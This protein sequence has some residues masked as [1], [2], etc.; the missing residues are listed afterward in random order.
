VNFKCPYYKHCEGNGKVF[1]CTFARKGKEYE[2]FINKP[3]CYRDIRRASTI[4]KESKKSPTIK[5]KGKES[6]K[7]AQMVTNQ[8]IANIWDDISI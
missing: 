5:E 1:H 2:S 6:P 4:E 8:V 3:A 7:I